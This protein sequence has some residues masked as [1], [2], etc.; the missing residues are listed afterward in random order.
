MT[1]PVADLAPGTTAPKP[2]AGPIPPVWEDPPP[3]PGAAPSPI[4]AVDGFEGPLDG[5]LAMARARK[6][7]LARL[8]IQA[9][10]EAFAEAMEAA[11]QRAP[12]VPAADLAR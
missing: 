3:G 11:L 12:N 4:L 5:L 10:V 2:R 9:L 1:E 8:T 7:D 6:I